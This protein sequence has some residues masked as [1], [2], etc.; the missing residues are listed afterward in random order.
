MDIAYWIIAGALALFYSYAGGTKVVQS[1]EQL[2]P[3]MGWIDTVPMW[4]V[5][6]IGVAEVLGAIGLVLPPLTGIAP[7]LAV[8][9]AGGFV[10]SQILAM[11]LHLSRGEV[12]ETGLNLTLIA[13]S[14]LAAWLATGL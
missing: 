12:K 13:L 10:V 3:M 1:K 6:S 2:R 7:G 14:G 8:V 11:A 9:A 4:L 5:R